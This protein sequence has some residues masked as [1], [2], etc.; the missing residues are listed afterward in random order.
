MP[1]Y[2]YACEKCGEI[3]SK[4]QKMS[5]G[6]GETTC[7]KCGSTEVTRKISA[8]AIGGTTGGTSAPAGGG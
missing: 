5:A 2:E 8:C 4:L 1:I 7:P 3:F 6:P